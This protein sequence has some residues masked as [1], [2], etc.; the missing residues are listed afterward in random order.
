MI[1]E[2]NVKGQSPE[3]MNP[4]GERN[5]IQQGIYSIIPNTMV[6][7]GKRIV[8]LTRHPIVVVRGNKKV[9]IPP[10]GIIVRT[11]RVETT[12]FMLGDIPVQTFGYNIENLPDPSTADYFIVPFVVA[13]AIACNNLIKYKGKI[14]VPNT[15]DAL[16][17]EKGFV[18]GVLSLLLAW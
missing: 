11:T 4:G 7:N 8:N 10:S 15:K 18:I 5:S 1:E 16:R 13:Q 2:R 6:I 9:R 17:N 3:M 12:A 14:L